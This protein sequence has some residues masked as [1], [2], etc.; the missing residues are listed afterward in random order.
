MRLCLAVLLVAGCMRSTADS[1]EPD[2]GGPQVT[3]PDTAAPSPDATELTGDTAPGAIEAGGEG[4]PETRPDEIVSLD[5]SMA[6]LV[7]AVGAISAPQKFTVAN[8][9]DAASGVPQVALSGPDAADFILSHDCT[10]ALAPGARC[11]IEVRFKSLTAGRKIATLSVTFSPGGKAVA[12]LEGL[13]LEGEGFALEPPF[14]DFGAVMV[15][16][17]SKPVTWTIRNLGGAPVT[18]GQVT[19]SSPAF[20]PMSGGCGGVTLKATERC[21]FQVA[22]RPTLAGPAVGLLSIDGGAAGKGAATLSGTGL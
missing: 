17:T 9:G 2:A 6:T 5:P 10:A 19:V 11:S 13:A 7:T 3:P 16:A 4:G 14:A 8:F 15:G 1:T 22:F 21:T 12:S 20:V 18:F